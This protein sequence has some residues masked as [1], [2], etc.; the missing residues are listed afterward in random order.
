ME[1]IAKEKGYT[2][3]EMSARK[4]AADFYRKLG[5]LQEGGIFKE[6]GIDHIRMTKSI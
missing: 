4:A 2:S 3:I 5:Y 6:V 1:L